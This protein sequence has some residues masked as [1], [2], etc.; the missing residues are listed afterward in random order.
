VAERGAEDGAGAEVHVAEP[1]ENYNELG[2]EDLIDR[3]TG[4]PTAVLAAVELYEQTHRHR[5][6]VLDAVERELR[7]AANQP[8]E[9]PNQPG[10]SQ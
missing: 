5:Q 3:I 2:A 6:T 7:R 9:S 10:E 8:G 1:W 4:A